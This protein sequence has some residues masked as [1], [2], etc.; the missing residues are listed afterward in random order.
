MYCN[1]IHT[2]VLLSIYTKQFKYS[3]FRSRNSS[4]KSIP[5]VIVGLY[6]NK[7]QVEMLHLNYSI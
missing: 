3:S 6:H 5:L 2:I 4:L 1:N 7:Q